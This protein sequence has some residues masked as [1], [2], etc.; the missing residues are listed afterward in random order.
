MEPANKP[1]LEAFFV[2]GDAKTE[3]GLLS[4]SDSWF[5]GVSVPVLPSSQAMFAV[6]VF[7]LELIRPDGVEFILLDPNGNDVPVTASPVPPIELQ[8]DSRLIFVYSRI[9]FEVKMEGR[10]KLYAV[11][12]HDIMDSRSYPL[13]VDLD[14]DMQWPPPNPTR[15]VGGRPRKPPKPRKRNPKRR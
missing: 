2:A 4:V 1:R 5:R 13:D 12:D 10:H 15:S 8:A 11:L 14:P 9:G 7:D 6:V 3:H